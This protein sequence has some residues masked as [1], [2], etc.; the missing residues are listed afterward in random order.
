MATGR[1]SAGINK[2]GGKN[3]NPVYKAAQT[4]TSYV[5]NAA[6]EIRDIPT[7]IGAPKRM[8]TGTKTIKHTSEDGTTNK[9][10]Y[11]KYKGNQASGIGA[12]LKEAAAAITAGQKGTSVGHVTASGKT[13]KRT[14]R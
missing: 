3:V 13:K 4:I 1:N 12:Q 6:R 10:K 2:T 9:Y 8:Q 11:P 7:S 14:Q 5:G